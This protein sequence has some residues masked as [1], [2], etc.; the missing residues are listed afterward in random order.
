MLCNSKKNTH[1]IAD[2][3]EQVNRLA[4]NFEQWQTVTHQNSQNLVQINERIDRLVQSQE[5]FQVQLEQSVSKIIETIDYTLNR[6]ELLVRQ[7]L[8]QSSN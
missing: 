4:A 8:E 1:Q 2:L 7:L 5:K 3:F 6:T